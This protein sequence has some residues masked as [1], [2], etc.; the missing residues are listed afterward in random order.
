MQINR[1][2]L[3]AGGKLGRTQERFNNKKNHDEVTEVRELWNKGTEGRR[4][5]HSA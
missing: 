5:R 2:F 3:K 4:R 1:L